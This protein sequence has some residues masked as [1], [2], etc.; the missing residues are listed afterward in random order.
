MFKFLKSLN[1]K[2]VI[3]LLS[4]LLIATV[5]L[6]IF[7][8]ITNA[9][10]FRDR[11]FSQLFPKPPSHAAGPG[12][13]FVDSS[14][15]VIT[16]TMSP[17]V[18]VELF[19]P[20]AIALKRDD[21]K[22]ALVK[23]ILAQSTTPLVL[24]AESMSLPSPAVQVYSDPSASGGK[25]LVFYS[26]ST[27][28]G[29]V[30][31]TGTTNNL[32]I[33]AKAD[34]CQGNPIMLVSVDE[35]NILNI[36]VSNTTFTDYTANV[37][38]SAGSHT[39]GVSF[40]NDLVRRN[41]DRNLRVD[42]LTFNQTSPIPTP[43]PTPSPSSVPTP[44]PDTTASPTPTPTPTPGPTTV[45]AILAEDAGF[46]KNVVT[47]QP[48]SANPTYINYTFSDASLGTKTLYV[49]YTSSSG[50]VQTF[51][52][53]IDLVAAPTPTPAP[54]GSN[55][56]GGPITDPDI[57][58]TC[59]AGV[60]DKYVVTGPDGQLYRT[61]HP[62][63]DPSGCTLGHDHGDDPRTSKANP[64]L[65]AFGYIGKQVGDLEPH[66]G[67]K[68]AV[69]NAGTVNDQN[70]VAY[71]D[72]RLVFHMGT[73]GVKR[74]V[75]QFHSMQFDL[76]GTGKYGGPV[77]EVRV[78]GMADTGGVGSICIDPREGKTVMQTD[79]MVDSSYEIWAFSFTIPDKIEVIASMAQLDPITIRDPSDNTR[80]LYVKDYK[81]KFG[82]PFG[83]QHG[84]GR[85][86]YF[87]PV[88]M[89]SPYD[90]SKETIYTDAYGKIVPDGTGFKQVF[91]HSTPE[92]YNVALIMSE[93][94]SDPNDIQAQ[95][96][97]AIADYC[98]P[99]IGLKN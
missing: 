97:T 40:T 62:V 64:A 12:I 1:Q 37:N 30:N 71:Y 35:V 24:E 95:A 4:L 46:T 93:D 22:F 18:R 21:S 54:S 83:E 96:K 67:F 88:H 58:G 6:L 39:V 80:L 8:T 52:N 25:A 20:Y 61:W 43:T 34:K 47:I 50:S 44:T 69:Q 98:A 53:S 45:S 36:D 78:M 82:T 27:A 91:T 26:N 11:L 85:E 41:C 16:Q 73:G 86:S 99:G 68:V 90:D 3:H 57:L 70:K 59:S 17:T 94:Q 76:I 65:P 31:T 32:V 66:P 13:Q 38:L 81:D 10:N 75:A 49:K 2:G 5:G 92:I 48:F 60:H 56:Y 33:R 72:T 7:I 14:N 84:C 63:K 29:T 89:L 19:S 79:C 23:E 77:K 74:Y 28:T 87:G 55:I 42:K 15:N 9:F 51:N